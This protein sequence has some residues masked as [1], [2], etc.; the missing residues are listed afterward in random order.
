MSLN[1]PLKGSLLTEE[2]TD[3]MGARPVAYAETFTQYAI[4]PQRVTSTPLFRRSTVRFP[5]SNERSLHG[6]R[7]TTSPVGLPPR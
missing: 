5:V 6:D 7:A 3:P 4:R 2:N 1:E